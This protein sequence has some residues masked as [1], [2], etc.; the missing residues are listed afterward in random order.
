M[1]HYVKKLVSDDGKSCGAIGASWVLQTPAS[2]LRATSARSKNISSQI[3]SLHY[4]TKS[5][6][7][8]IYK[9]VY[10]YH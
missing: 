9:I 7:T 6:S 4:G 8:R 3:I 10:Y 2:N 5:L 1:T